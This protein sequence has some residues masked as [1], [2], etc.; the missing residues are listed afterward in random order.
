MLTV[1][2]ECSS[3]EDGDVLRNHP[4][5]KKSEEMW[6]DKHP[7]SRFL[8]LA[9][10]VEGLPEL[11]GEIT[12]ERSTLYGKPTGGS[13]IYLNGIRIVH[14]L[15]DEYADALARLLAWGQV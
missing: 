7:G 14:S 9:Q 10:I 11:E 13:E 4:E 2:D 6:R 12:V 8:D 5:Y 3:D 1:I 15:R